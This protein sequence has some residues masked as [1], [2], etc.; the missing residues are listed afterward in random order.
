MTDQTTN[1]KRTRGG[2]ILAT[3]ALLALAAGV[4][5]ITSLALFTDQ[6]SA[7]GNAFSTGTIDLTATPASAII[8][9][10]NMA[11]G[12]QVTRP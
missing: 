3:V 8:T 10:P 9:M 7:P 4:L 5:T 12:D 6:E 11:P 2:R 1:D